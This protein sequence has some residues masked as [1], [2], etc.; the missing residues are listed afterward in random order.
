M[1]PTMKFSAHGVTWSERGT[2]TNML[3]ICGQHNCPIDQI[4]ASS[5]TT[6]ANA[7]CGGP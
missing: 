5:A 6:W 2:R 1:L 4:A 3:E 7:A